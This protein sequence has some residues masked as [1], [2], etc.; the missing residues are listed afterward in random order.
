M[1]FNEGTKVL[2]RIA[3][4][5]LKMHER[6]LLAVKD[7]GDLHIL[8]NSIGR[9]VVDPDVI[10]ACAYK[11]YLCPKPKPKPTCTLIRVKSIVF[12]LI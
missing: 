11:S 1:L 8:L 7:T 6:E 12:V 4:A 5:L 9:R 10:I 3:I 2:F